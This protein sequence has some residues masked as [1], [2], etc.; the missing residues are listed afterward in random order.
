M[1]SATIVAIDLGKYKSVAC[2]Y[3]AGTEPAFAT[4]ASNAEALLRLCHQHRPGVVVRRDSLLY[5]ARRKQLP[6]LPDPVDGRRRSTVRA[7]LRH[8]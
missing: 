3:R 5:P 6:F 4:L 2:A 7:V 1:M 8:P